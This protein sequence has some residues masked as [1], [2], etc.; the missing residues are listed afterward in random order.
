[1]VNQDMHEHLECIMKEMTDDIRENCPMD[2]IRLLFWEHQLQALQKKDKCQ[3]HWPLSIIKFISGGAY[4]SCSFLVLP[5][6]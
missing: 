6:H 5:S 3:S 2:S 4:R 1:M